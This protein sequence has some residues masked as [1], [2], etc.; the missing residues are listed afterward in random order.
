MHFDRG[1]QTEGTLRNRE[2][3]TMY[4]GFILSLSGP[5]VVIMS[6]YYFIKL[7]TTCFLAGISLFLLPMYLRWR[8]WPFV[9]LFLA[10]GIIGIILAPSELGTICIIATTVL[11][12]WL[13]G[14]W[15]WKVKRAR[16]V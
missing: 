2:V 7:G 9:A 5:L 12:I 16:R 8:L 1:E 4:I 11:L 14:L 6:H 15:C 13:S 3:W 10:L